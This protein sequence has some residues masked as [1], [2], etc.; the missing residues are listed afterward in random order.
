VSPPVDGREI[1]QAFLANSPFGQLVGLELVELGEGTAELSLPFR[2][3][4]ATAGEVVHGGAIS[5]LIDTAA[6]AAAWATEFDEMPKRWGTASLTV[7]YLRAAEG[8][9]LRASARVDRRGRSLCYCSVT[10]TAGGEPT[11]TGLVVYALGGT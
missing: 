2:E 3:E 1:A 11:A 10:V 5:T 4:V 9:D 6:T 8:S 7:T